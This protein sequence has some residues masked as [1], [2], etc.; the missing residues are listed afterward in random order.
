MSTTPT[1]LLTGPV[2]RL[3][4]WADA[5]RAIDWEPFEYFTVSYG[6]AFHPHLKHYETYTI[7]D[8]IGG[9]EACYTMGPMFDPEEPD[10]GPFPEEDAQYRDFYIELMSPWFEELHR[11]VN[12]DPTAYAIAKTD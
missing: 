5:V 11:Q 1:V 9:V 10:A 3:P 4:E 6:N 2:D 7:S 8:A 12:E